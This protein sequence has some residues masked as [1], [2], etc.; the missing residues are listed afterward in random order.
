[1]VEGRET[2]SDNEG[3]M[4]I[5]PSR[6]LVLCALPVDAKDA[7]EFFQIRKQDFE[8]LAPQVCWLVLRLV[9]LHVVNSRQDAE[10]R[11]TNWLPYLTKHTHQLIN[12]RVRGYLT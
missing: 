8:E 7:V 2:D 3:E 5:D 6:A 11:L 10:A 12:E 1:M 4:K 9:S